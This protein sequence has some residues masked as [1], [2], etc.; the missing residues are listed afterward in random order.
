[1]FARAPVCSYVSIR[2]A[3]AN[4]KT[5][6]N[7]SNTVWRLSVRLFVLATVAACQIVI[8]SAS[9]AAAEGPKGGDKDSTIRPFNLNATVPD[10]VT[11][12]DLKGRDSETRVMAPNPISP[13]KGEIFRGSSHAGV[14]IPAS[15]WPDPDLFVEL[16]VSEVKAIPRGTGAT[17]APRANGNQ[18]Q[19]REKLS[20]VASTVPLTAREKFGLFATN[21]FKPPA[22]YAMSILS[23][24]FAEATDSKH[25]KP[26][27]SAGDFAADSLTHA[28]RSYAFR[29]TSSFFEKFAYA[30]VFKQDPRY[31]RSPYTSFGAR[32]KYAVTRVFVTQ[33]DRNGKNEFNISFL[34]GG[35]TAAAISNV[36]EPT[37]NQTGA[38]SLKRFGTHVGLKALSNI[39][40]ELI[41][42]Q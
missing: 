1:M 19:S 11:V 29:V 3:N 39:L 41:G 42:G 5:G 17:D 28:A 23:G 20:T 15:I 24:V 33:G 8:A 31:H 22:P 40:S 35:L 4:T 36:W 9:A 37:Y 30:T 12:R 34:A 27:R 13:G 32:L 2:A 10:S 38:A 21:S 14:E 7:M 16:R 6:V 18:A 26:N 25:K